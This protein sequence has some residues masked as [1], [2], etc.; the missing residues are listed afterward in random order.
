MTRRLIEQFAGRP[1]PRSLDGL[2]EREREVLGLI[3]QG[4]STTEITRRLYLGMGTVGRTG[5][6]ASEVER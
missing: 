6:P 4:L 1:E 3:A 5:D 2:T